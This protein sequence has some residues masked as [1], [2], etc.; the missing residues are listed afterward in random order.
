MQKARKFF[1]LPRDFFH[2]VSSLKN[3]SSRRQTLASFIRMFI[4]KRGYLPMTRALPCEF[5]LFNSEAVQ[6]ASSFWHFSGR[7]VHKMFRVWVSTTHMDGSL[8]QKVS[9]QASFFGRVSLNMVGFGA[10]VPKNSLKIG[11]FS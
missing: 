5:S 6:E 2:S 1:S 7:R 10:K 9:K 8:C 11:S 4:R 3:D